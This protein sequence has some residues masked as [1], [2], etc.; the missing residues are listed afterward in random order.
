MTLVQVWT[1]EQELTLEQ[2]L[3]LKIKELQKWREKLPLQPIEQ[4]PWL[5]GAE[6]LGHGSWLLLL[7]H[8]GVVGEQLQSGLKVEQ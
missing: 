3:R 2:V 8:D 7:G 6:Q 1:L 5:P 4:L